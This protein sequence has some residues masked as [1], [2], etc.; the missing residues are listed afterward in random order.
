MS[1]SRVL[2]VAVWAALTLLVGFGL[3]ESLGR[4]A[5]A[6]DKAQAAAQAKAEDYANTVLY[7]AITPGTLDEPI[8]SREYGE[9]LVDVQAGILSDDDVVR[10]RIWNGAGELAFSSDQRDRLGQEID[11]EDVL[12][13]VLQGSAVSEKTGERVP[14][15]P[16]LAGA[17]EPL[18]ETYAPLRLG[19]QT[20]P[21]GVAEIQQ[22]YSA[23]QSVADTVWRPIQ[24]GLGVA[25]LGALVML[26]VSIRS[27]DGRSTALGDPRAAERVRSLERRLRDAE[28]RA[29]ESGER[30]DAMM[31]A[32]VALEEQLA[33]SERNLRDTLTARRANEE[34][35]A[36]LIERV[37]QLERQL[38]EARARALAAEAA[39]SG[40]SPEDLAAA[41]ARATEAA[42][43]RDRLAA[44]VERL[45]AVATEG[46]AAHERALDLETRVAELQAAGSS[47][48]ARVAEAEARAAAAEQ[49][50]TEADRRVAE[51]EERLTKSLEQTRSDLDRTSL[52]LS[53]TQAALAESAD[54]MERL[55]ADLDAARREKADAMSALENAGQATGDRDRELEQLRTNVMAR[56]AEL[57][58]LRTSVVAK[59]AELEQLRAE[60]VAKNEELERMR[61]EVRE[62]HE[63]LASAQLE[64]TQ[65]RGRIEELMGIAIGSRAAAFS[66]PPPGRSTGGET[67]GD[68][69]PSSD[70]TEELSIR[71]RLLRAAAARERASA[72]PDA[73][74]R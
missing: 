71:E 21:S 44:E 45:N 55:Q 11:A 53:E 10:V 68:G 30:V 39:S 46:T 40:V 22:R 67:T 26:V 6:V 4:Q 59:N 66:S 13:T 31:A 41:H 27:G 20:S 43:E 73:T 17:N 32:K 23:I 12:R 64:M 42:S 5:D 3:Y 25:L 54:K 29:R 36:S 14:Q 60:A 34:E 61:G 24:A 33:T 65:A 28:K 9:L 1:V 56:D 2:R 8:E 50:A 51:V 16:G 15:L 52:G 57:E 58:Q 7:R 72:P 37:P 74:Q 49:R 38:A 63:Q 19:E 47:S 69:A 62:A 35:A 70:G 18:L 48:D